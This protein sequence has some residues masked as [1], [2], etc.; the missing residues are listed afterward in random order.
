LKY[1]GR[2]IPIRD[3]PFFEEKRKGRVREGLGG[4]EGRETVIRIDVK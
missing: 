2:L 4:K 1:L 3:L